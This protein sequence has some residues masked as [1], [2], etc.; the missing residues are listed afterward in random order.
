MGTHQ[1]VCLLVNPFS[2]HKVALLANLFQ[3][4]LNIFWQVY[5]AS[6][7]P[8]NNINTKE[9]GDLTL[10]LDGLVVGSISCLLRLSRSLVF[11]LPLS[12]CLENNRWYV[13]CF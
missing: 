12:R 8:S 9:V 11:H 2:G 4:L 1:H 3:L 6:L 10:H 13:P 5:K 7:Y